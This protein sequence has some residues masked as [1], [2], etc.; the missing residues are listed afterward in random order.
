MDEADLESHGAVTRFGGYNHDDWAKYADDM[1]FEQG[2]EDRDRALVERD[3]NRPCVIIWSLGNES[4][5]GKA[6]IK[7]A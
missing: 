5:F 7:G 6:F 2:I 3:K 1:R 4:G